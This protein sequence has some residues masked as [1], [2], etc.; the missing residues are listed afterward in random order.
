MY[1]NRTVSVPELTK[2]G[3][4]VVAKAAEEIISVNVTGPIEECTVGFDISIFRNTA[5][6]GVCCMMGNALSGYFSGKVSLKVI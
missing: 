2:F 4:S 1:P 6:V 5:A 3:T